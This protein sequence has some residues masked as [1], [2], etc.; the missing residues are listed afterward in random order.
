MTCYR[1]VL[2]LVTHRRTPVAQQ[3]QISV[4]SRNVISSEMLSELVLCQFFSALVAGDGGATLR[5]AKRQL[6]WASCSAT[7]MTAG[8]MTVQLRWT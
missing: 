5:L 2:M 3:P 4:E 6:M 1:R 8:D 7:R